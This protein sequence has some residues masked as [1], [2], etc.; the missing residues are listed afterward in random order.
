M[1]PREIP[2]DPVCV[3]CSKPI[4]PG[5]FVVSEH[6]DL[7]HLGCRSWNAQLRSVE[8]VDRATRA[9]ERNKRLREDMILLRAARRPRPEPTGACPLCGDA[10]TLT[11]WR[12]T[13]DWIAVEDCPCGGFFAWAPLLSERVRRL[14]ARDRQDFARRIRA[15]RASGDEAWFAT[16]DGTVAGTLVVRTQR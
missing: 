16:T 7:F 4:P 1:S 5:S 6:G 8:E 3:A 14:P 10:A 15:F 9:Q 13:A 2:A 11:D 12:P